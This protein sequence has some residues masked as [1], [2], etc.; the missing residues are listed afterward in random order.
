MAE[1]VASA[2]CIKLNARRRLV[3]GRGFSGQITNLKTVQ[4]FNPLNHI[5]FLFGVFLLFFSLYMCDQL[6]SLQHLKGHISEILLVLI[7]VQHCF[8]TFKS[9][10]L[11]F[12]FAFIVWIENNS[13]FRL[14]L[15]FIFL[16]A[17]FIFCLKQIL[18]T[19]HID[20]SANSPCF[21]LY[22][23]LIGQ[24]YEYQFPICAINIDPCCFS[25]QL[26]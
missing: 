7:L 2:F 24:K 15:N 20:G 4:R 22:V 19:F 26:L 25:C 3:T 14:N 12:E 23:M 10:F 18:N 11:K 16:H 9:E 6:S 5:F 1:C 8:L 21:Q 13:V 17:F